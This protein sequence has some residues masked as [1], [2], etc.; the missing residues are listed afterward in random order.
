MARAVSGG[1]RRMT[2]GGIRAD[3]LAGLTTAAVVVPQA[4]AYSAI[5]GLPV[6]SGLYCALVPMVVYAL[7]GTSRPLSVSTTSTLSALTAGAIAAAD[8]SRPAV[9]AATLGVLTGVVLLLGGILRFGFAADF[10]S[11]P[12]LTGFKA[13]VGLSIAASQLSK[14]LG[15]PVS[16]NG[17]LDR[18]WSALRHLS[19]THAL[20]L[21]VA[22]GALAGLLALRRFAPK[23]PAPLLILVAG[24]VVSAVFTLKG[25][26]V[27]TVGTVP[28]GL[29]RPRL[30]DFGLTRRLVGPACGVALMAFVESIA[31]ARA[32]RT[33]DDPPLVA[34]RELVALG[35]AGGAG[36]FFQAY[37]AG[38]GLSQTAVNNA[39]GAASKRAGLVTAACVAATLLVLAPVFGPLPQAVLGAI[40]LVAVIGLIDVGA[41]ERIG[42]ARRGE[43]VLA[44]LTAVGVVAFG[45]LAGIVVAIALSLQ[46]LIH[47][48]DHPPVLVVR[49]DPPG[50]LV[51]KVESQLFFANARRVCDQV[52][53]DVD[54]APGTRVLLLDLGTVPDID[55][56][57]GMAIRGLHETLAERGVELWF[58]AIA[59]V[60]RQTMEATGDWPRLVAAHRFHPTVD[61]GVEQYL[62]SAR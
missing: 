38:G 4:M 22:L 12:V 7:V 26:G 58:A 42:R 3:G 14:L 56:S 52:L 25:H 32:F 53:A 2:R 28:R 6:Q 39:S 35:L 27:D 41:F 18:C 40:V 45:T 17:V 44:L 13:G 57:A 55:V 19:Q 60:P 8:P 61:A 48:I 33:S 62:E 1:E 50:L 36:G 34:N 46:M 29:P 10:I 31:A 49:R 24:I 20:T 43:F 59:S 15:Y 11:D 21:A 30:P 51:L 37:P 47:R 5:A 9:V 23:S 54:G 16:G